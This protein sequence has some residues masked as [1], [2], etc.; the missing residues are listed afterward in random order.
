[1]VELE[2][3]KT[4]VWMSR[5]FVSPLVVAR[6]ERKRYTSGAESRR[7]TYE[8]YLVD[9]RRGRAMVHGL[10]V[11]EALSLAAFILLTADA[12]DMS[13]DYRMRLRNAAAMVLSEARHVMRE[14][15][16]RDVYEGWQA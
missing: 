1:M 16:P 11:E 13:D 12:S 2:I 9:E 7:T 15:I 6:H 8:I 10:T 5:Y 4:A 3:E 14:A